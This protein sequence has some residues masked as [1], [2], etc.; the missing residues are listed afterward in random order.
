MELIKN[1]PEL[2]KS[3]DAWGKRG[4]KWLTDG[5]HLAMS[6]LS[7]LAEHGDTMPLNRLFLA[8]P[9]GSKT[10]AMAEWILAY[11]NVIPNEDSANAKVKPFLHTKDKKCDLVEGAKNPWYTFQPEPTVLESFGAQAA[12]IAALQGVLKK[13]AGATTVVNPAALEQATALIELL[14]AEA[15][16]DEGE[17][18]EAAPAGNADPLAL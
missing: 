11:A 15:V 5:H 16:D 4:K 2:N 17:T 6:A 7:I 18:T 1:I 12:M 13:A 10:G 8:M 9:K 3:I 14:S